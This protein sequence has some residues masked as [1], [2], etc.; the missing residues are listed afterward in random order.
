MTR[1]F[2]QSL[3]RI[4]ALVGLLT[5]LPASPLEG[6]GAVSPYRFLEGKHD[7]GFFLNQVPG[8]RGVMELGPGDGLMMGARYGIELSGPFALEFSG[9]L[10]PTDREVRIPNESEESIESF[11]QTDVLVGGLDGRIRFTLTGARTWHGLAPF[12][13]AG[14]GFAV[15]LKGATEEESELPDELR[16]KFGPTFLGVASLGTRWV[17]T[18]RLHLRVEAGS[19]LWKLGTPRSFQSLPE[20][21]GTVVQQQW[22]AVGAFGVGASWRF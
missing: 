1:H 5:L 8:N 22:P 10:L 9:F 13:T 6:Q 20:A 7:V 12:V 14:G 3:P 21:S 4:L 11:G 19:Y 18:D 16:F 15:N 17:V 2:S